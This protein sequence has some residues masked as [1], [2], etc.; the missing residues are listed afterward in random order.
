V[1]F[2]WEFW[3]QAKQPFSKSTKEYIE[4][5]DAE[6]DIEYLRDNDIELHSSS[7][8]VLKVSTMLL[9]KASKLDF[10]PAD[11]AAIMSRSV[12]TRMSD[13]EKLVAKAASTAI[14]ACRS[15]RG[16][17]VHKSPNNG[18]FWNDLDEEG[19]NAES[20]FMREFERALDAYLAERER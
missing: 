19:E 20:I 4:T 11:I 6:E 10:P 14:C 17:L 2:E 15:E 3:P 9:Q 18:S 8:R 16:E 12:P 13:V 1:C 5:L 7:E